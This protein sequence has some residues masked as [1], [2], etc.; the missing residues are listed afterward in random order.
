MYIQSWRSDWFNW[1][2]A[3]VSIA[4]SNYFLVYYTTLKSEVAS[5][6]PFFKFCFDE[7]VD[8][9]SAECCYEVFAN[10]VQRLNVS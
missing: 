2:F 1:L 3:F 4:R 6:S 5:K 10:V 9:S 7:K 8:N